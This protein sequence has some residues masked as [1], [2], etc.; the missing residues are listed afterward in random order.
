M[1]YSELEHAV[2]ELRESLEQSNQLKSSLNSDLIQISN[3]SLNSL[4]T[5]MTTIGREMESAITKIESVETNLKR[6]E[7]SIKNGG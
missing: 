3:G 1:N 5:K 7:N 6:I 2:S 4:V